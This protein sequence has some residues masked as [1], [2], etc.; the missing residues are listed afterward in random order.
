MPAWP[1]SFLPLGASVLTAHMGWRLQRK[2]TAIPA[3]HRQFRTLINRMA[4]TSF[5][6]A[7]GL[8][9]GMSY[10][11]F[12]TRVAPRTYEDLLLPIEQ[13]KR[14]EA[15]VLWPGQ[16]A[17]YAVSSGITSGYTKYL[18]ITEE[19]MAHF[20]QAGLDSLLYYTART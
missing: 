5:W 18:P 8:E 17:L 19:M 7:A 15:N 16:C 14:G 6:Q 13:M 2:R 9:S 3:Q 11:S 10:D 1:K 4:K 20:R 12:R